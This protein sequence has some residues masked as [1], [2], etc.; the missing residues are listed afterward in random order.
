LNLKPGEKIRNV[1]DHNVKGLEV[2]IPQVGRWNLT[3]N[4][5]GWISARN[6]E[7]GITVYENSSGFGESNMYVKVIE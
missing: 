6:D 3:R 4:C 5:D 7:N 1:S 2:I